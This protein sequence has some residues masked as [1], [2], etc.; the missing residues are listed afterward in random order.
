MQEYLKLI[1]KF[2]SYKIAVLIGILVVL[3]DFFSKRAVVA[4]MVYGETI[5]VMQC[6]NIVRVHNYGMSF[7]VFSNCLPQ[8]VVIALVCGMIAFVLFWAMRNR[9]YLPLVIVIVCGA[10]GN[11]VDRLL[12][13]YVVDFFDFFIYEWH[14]PA[15]NV[16]DCAIVFCNFNILLMFLF[17][18]TKKVG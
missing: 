17:D 18:N 11:V 1:K 14:W 6:F 10:I 8:S 4:S 15:F 13:G 3:V 2:Q 16:A 7:G 12:Y 9:Q 5:N